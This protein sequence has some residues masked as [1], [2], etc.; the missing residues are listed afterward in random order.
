MSTSVA[1]IES[2]KTNGIVWKTSTKDGV[3]WWQ[4]PNKLE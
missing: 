2:A 4:T 1:I 3:E